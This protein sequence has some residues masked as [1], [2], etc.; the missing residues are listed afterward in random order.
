MSGS[1]GPPVKLT[2]LSLS[3]PCAP[4]PLDPFQGRSECVSCHLAQSHYHPSDPSRSPLSP[5]Q[6]GTDHPVPRLPR[7][8]SLC[9]HTRLHPP[10][11]CFK[12]VPTCVANHT[13]LSPSRPQFPTETPGSSLSPPLMASCGFVSGPSLASMGVTTSGPSP[14]TGNPL[15]TAGSTCTPAP[16]TSSSTHCQIPPSGSHAASSTSHAFGAGNGSGND[17]KV[18]GDREF[19]AP[20]VQYSRAEYPRWEPFPFVHLRDLCKAQRDFGQ[21]SSYFKSLVWAAF[22]TNILVP[23]D[24]KSIMSCILSPAEF[25]LWERSWKTLLRDLLQCYQRDPTRAH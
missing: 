20:P 5:P 13:I 24:I 17:Q 9:P 18:G 25:L 4:Y 11:F 3:S 7:P 23:H 15:P 16:S 6:D 19:T 2:P 1:L 14:D 12:M 21:E 8:F 10:Q 22:I